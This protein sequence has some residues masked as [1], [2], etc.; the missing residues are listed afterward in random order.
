MS[1]LGDGEYDIVI[2]VSCSEVQSAIPSAS[3]T[4]SPLAKVVVDRR[5]PADFPQ[6]ARPAG[7]YFPGDDISIAFD[8]PIVCSVLSVQAKVSDGTMLSQ[9][10]FL[11][12]CAENTLFLDFAPSMSATVR[13]ARCV[14]VYKLH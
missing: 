10:D 9:S 13:H 1:T 12:H 5:A 11:V 2:R 4:F 3:T 8:E 14:Y 7:P 6:H